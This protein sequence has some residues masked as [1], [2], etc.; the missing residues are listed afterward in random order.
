MLWFKKQSSQQTVIE[1]VMP[2]ELKIALDETICGQKLQQLQ[3]NTAGYGGIDVFIESLS[4]KHRLFNEAIVAGAQ[5]EREAVQTLLD[6]V[7]TARRKLPKIL[8]EVPHE[9]VVAQIQELMNGKAP[10]QERMQGFVDVIATEQRKMRGAAWDFAAELL[11]FAWPERYPLMS[12]WVWDVNSVSG[13]MREFIRANDSLPEI[14]IGS[15]P[16]QYEAGRL[17][18]SERLSEHGY[19]RDVPFLI[20]LLL[21]QAY[22]DYVFAM[23]SGMGMVGMMG[24]EF[25]GKLEP[26]DFISKLLGVDAPRKTGDSRDEMLTVH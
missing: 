3:A 7:F 1:Q 26:I 24:G 20:D 4:N 25:G 22:T 8:S 17:W 12:R 15:E 5:L 11:H 19:Y 2:G 18:L 14:P 6:T 10:L 16:E 21:A 9:I 13:A 23:S